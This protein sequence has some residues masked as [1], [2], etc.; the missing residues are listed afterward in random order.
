VIVTHGT[1]LV[2]VHVQSLVVVTVSVLDMPAAGAVPLMPLATD[3]WHFNEVGAVTSME[4]EDEP[5]QAA[6]N[7]ARANAAYSRARI[8]ALDVASRLPLALNSATAEHRIGSAVAL[9]RV[10]GKA[11]PAQTATRSKSRDACR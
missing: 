1:P 5:V 11:A 8:A 7:A 3:T 9:E 6:L 4:E 2:A 10:T